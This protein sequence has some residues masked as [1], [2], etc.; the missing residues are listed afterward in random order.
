MWCRMTL[1]RDQEFTKPSSAG[2]Q[3]QVDVLEAIAVTLVEPASA[4]KPL[5]IDEATRGC[6]GRHFEQIT[7]PGAAAGRSRKW[8]G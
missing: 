2:A 5:A 6:H 3:A 8:I 1:L 4:P 7:A